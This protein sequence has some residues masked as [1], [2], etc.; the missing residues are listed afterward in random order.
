MKKNF[1][2]IFSILVFTPIVISWGVWGHERINRAAVFA[3]PEPLRSYFYHYI[4]YLTYEASVPDLRKYVLQDK[5]E[6]QKHFL[7]IENFG[8]FEN[9]PKDYNDAEKKFGKDFLNN[10]GILYWHLKITFEKLTEAFKKQ[11]I[12]E[13]LFIAA[14]FGHYIA[15]AH[16]PFHVTA[17]YNGQ[18][19]GHKGI[20][21]LWESLIPEKFGYG[22]NFYVGEAKYIENIDEEILKILKHSNSLVDSALKAYD[23]AAKEVKNIY[24]TDK[25]GNIMKNSY[26]EYLYTDEFIVKFNY[27]LNGMVE[28]Q[29]K[30]SVVAVS[31][32]W[33]TAWVNAGKPDLSKFISSTFDKINFKKL[34]KE[35]K[36]YKKGALIA[37]P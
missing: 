15:D 27:Y 25:D 34:K 1:V 6:S 11:R 32:F 8:G 22:Y 9:L 17:N 36:Y 23:L 28:K 16:M 24:K 19:T 31:S 3:L 10:N 21:G 4:D 29:L 7:D 30:E 18:L 33:Y 37:L 14:D 20:H 5:N 26:G 2:L 35:L 12:N 13:I